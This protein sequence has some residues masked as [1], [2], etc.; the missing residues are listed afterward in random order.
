MRIHHIVSFIVDKEKDRPDGKLRMRVRWGGD[1][2]VAVNLGYRVTLEKWSMESQRCK[3]NTT[4]GPKKIP[5]S[6]INA[7]I[8]RYELAAGTAFEP[9]ERAGREPSEAEYRDALR[10]ALGRKAGVPSRS[11]KDIIREYLSARSAERGWAGET[12]KVNERTLLGIVK[13]YPTLSVQEMATGKWLSYW[14]SDMAFRGIRNTTIK[15]R[16][17]VSKPFLR[18]ARK[19]GYVESDEAQ[20]FSPRIKTVPRAVVWLGWDELM[21]FFRAEVRPDAHGGRDELAKDMF[22]LSCFTSLR[23]SDMKNLKWSDI[24]G[25]GIHRVL[26]KTSKPITIEFNKYSRAIIEKYRRRPLSEVYVF[27]EYFPNNFY[28]NKSLRAVAKSLGFVRPITET[29]FVG[30]SRQ[31]RT[32]P[33]C[34]CLTMHCG[35]RTFICNA[36]EMGIPPEVVMQWT[37]HSCYASMKPYIAVSDKAKARAMRGFDK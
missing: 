18:W 23:I 3:T 17:A 13:N 37:G 25:A 7:E 29:Y 21:Q 33:L 11:L 12:E 28:L 10:E 30:A 31:E 22:C 34:E 14:V 6:E 16:V 27:G 24:D 15:T 20:V 8:Q 1:R 9:F 2:R 35:R 26:Q 19:Q 36:L 4:H 5:A 32:E